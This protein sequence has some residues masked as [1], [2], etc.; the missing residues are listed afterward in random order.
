MHLW[1]ASPALRSRNDVPSIKRHRERS[2]AIQCD[3]KAF[4]FNW[5]ATDVA[6]LVMILGVPV[7]SLRHY[8]AALS[9]CG[10]PV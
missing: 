5:I 7:F 1:I 10:N 4:L 2:V 9:G 6:V 8:E 3:Y